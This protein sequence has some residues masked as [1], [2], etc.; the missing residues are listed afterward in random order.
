MAATI[1]DLACLNG[2]PLIVLT[3]VFR[4]EQNAL[5]APN[6]HP[7]PEGAARMAKAVADYLK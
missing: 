2:L 1:S 5:Y 6:D 3:D 4:G 7:N